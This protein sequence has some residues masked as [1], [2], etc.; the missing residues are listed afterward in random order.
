MR[1]ILSELVEPKE[2]FVALNVVTSTCNFLVRVPMM[3]V[4]NKVLCC[5]GIML[6]FDPFILRTHEGPSG[7]LQAG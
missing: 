1:L 4:K 3:M 2:D 7:S 6:L 5:T